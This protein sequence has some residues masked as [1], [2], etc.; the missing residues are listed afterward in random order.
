MGLTYQSE[1]DLNAIT[2]GTL[3]SP[4]LI[5][6]VNALRKVARSSGKLKWMHRSLEGGQGSETK[7]KAEKYK[8]IPSV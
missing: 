7:T 2:Y 6:C 8:K 4:V 1:K 3:Q 5:L